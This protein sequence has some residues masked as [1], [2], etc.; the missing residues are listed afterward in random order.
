STRYQSIFSWSPST[1]VFK[2]TCSQPLEMLVC[3]IDGSS[4]FP[5][6]NSDGSSTPASRLASVSMGPNDTGLQSTTWREAGA[7]VDLNIFW[8]GVGDSF[9]LGAISGVLPTDCIQ[10]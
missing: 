10:H 8:C 5:V 3:M 7:R 2:N 6:C 4:E 9:T 1:L